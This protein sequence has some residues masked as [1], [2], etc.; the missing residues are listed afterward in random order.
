MRNKPPL[1]ALVARVTETLASGRKER[2]LQWK[3]YALYASCAGRNRPSRF[4]R[5]QETAAGVQQLPAVRKR[6]R[7]RGNSN[8]STKPRKANCLEPATPGLGLIGHDPLLQGWAL[9]RP[10][11]ETSNP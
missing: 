8:E 4:H 1:H 6:E 7:E 11:V 9:S 10:M 5:T 3:L 2:N